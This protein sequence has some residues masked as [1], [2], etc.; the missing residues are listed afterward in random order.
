MNSRLRTANCP[1]GVSTQTPDRHLGPDVLEVLPAPKQSFHKLSPDTCSS[2]PHKFRSHPPVLTPHAQSVQSPGGATSESIRSHPLLS[3]RPQLRCQ[4][5][6]SF[7]S[8]P[9]KSSHLVSMSHFCPLLSI[10]WIEQP[11]DPEKCTSDSCLCSP[12]HPT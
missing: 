5:P 12:F 10:F 3:P 6:S 9:A 8:A 1:F 7:A 2:A 11:G 4:P